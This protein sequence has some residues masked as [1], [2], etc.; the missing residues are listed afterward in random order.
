MCLAIPTCAYQHHRAL[1]CHPN[2]TCYLPSAKGTTKVDVLLTIVHL[3]VPCSCRHW[4]SCAAWRA[5]SLSGTSAAHCPAVCLADPAALPSLQP[6]ALIWTQRNSARC[7]WTQLQELGAQAAAAAVAAAVAVVVAAAAAA[8]C[9]SPL[10][11]PVCSRCCLKFA[12]CPV[13]CWSSG[14]GLCWTA[15]SFT[16]ASGWDTGELL[17][18]NLL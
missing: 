2:L 12:T 5:L 17:L 14:L 3:V 11:A 4:C 15:V 8:A 18:R 10:E 9:S 16:A 7:Q 6:A 13:W 1:Q